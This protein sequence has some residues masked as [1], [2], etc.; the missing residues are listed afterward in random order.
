MAVTLIKAL[1]RAAHRQCIGGRG[2][3][4]HVI[5]VVTRFASGRSALIRKATVQAA[6][7]A[8][9]IHHL[10]SFTALLT[11]AACSQHSGGRTGTGSTSAVGGP[12]SKKRWDVVVASHQGLQV[13]FGDGQGQ[14]RASEQGFIDL[15][16]TTSATLG[17]LDGD[18]DQDL[19]VTRYEKNPNQVWFNDGAGQ[20]RNSGQSLGQEGNWRV[21]LGDLD[22]DGDLDAFVIGAFN[23]STSPGVAHP[24]EIWLNDGKGFFTDTG[25]RLGG[26]GGYDAR[27]IDLDGDGDLDAVVV[28]LGGIAI[29]TNQG[30]ATFRER[31][32]RLGDGSDTPVCALAMG[33]LDGDGKLDIFSARG[34]RGE[35]RRNRG[36]GR[37]E[38]EQVLDRSFEAISVA[39]GD[40]D[41]D[42]DLDAFLGTRAEHLNRVLF[43]NGKGQ[44]TDSGQALP[45]GH[46][47]DVALVD[48]DGDGDL[49][50]IQ[51]NRNSPNRVLLND[52]KGHFS[53][54]GRNLGNLH[55]EW[56]SRRIA[57][58]SLR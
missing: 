48:C 30:K 29:W 46:T 40:L 7:H 1:E 25:Q 3:T 44:F 31:G 37:F 50:A 11:L 33:D 54:S 8:M 16:S 53:D 2:L 56:K 5:S 32:P 13:W 12:S 38:L 28:E 17:D 49:D 6:S 15:P 52:G 35:V 34:G 51:A 14:F 23:M 36:E 22:G 9:C 45:A 4:V 55:G 43:N 18:G 10:I 58:G 26:T 41:G 57:V 20:F 24:R 42:G 19:F 27:L 21:A 39:L 47:L